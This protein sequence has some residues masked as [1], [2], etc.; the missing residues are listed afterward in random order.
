MTEAAPFDICVIGGGPA[1]LAAAEAAS[2]TGARI[3]LAE[4]M[5]SLGRKFLMAGKSGL[6]LTKDERA[7]VFRRHITDHPT[8]DPTLEAFGPAEVMEW[9]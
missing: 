7:D 4:R 2:Q 8:L 9:A 1:G 6:N 3:L 5:P